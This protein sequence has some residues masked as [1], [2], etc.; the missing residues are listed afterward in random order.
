[1]RA[2][3]TTTLLTAS[4]SAQASNEQAAGKPRFMGVGVTF[5]R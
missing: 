3:R 2:L 1:M 4:L 5:R